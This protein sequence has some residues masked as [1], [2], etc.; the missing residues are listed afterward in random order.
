MRGAILHGPHDIRFDDADVLPP[1]TT[2]PRSCPRHRRQLR[3]S[4]VL[5]LCSP[6]TSFVFGVA[7]PVDG[8]C[9]AQ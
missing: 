5:W 3:A 1:S 6:G 9:T 8:G 4:T 7:L 2:S